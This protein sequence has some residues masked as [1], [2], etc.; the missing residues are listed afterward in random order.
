[1]NNALTGA[2]PC[3]AGC[4][5]YTDSCFR[6]DCLH[7]KEEPT[8]N[9]NGHNIVDYG[10]N[11]PAT[12]LQRAFRYV[13]YNARGQ[14]VAAFNRVED[15]TYLLAFLEYAVTPKKF[16]PITRPGRGGY[17]ITQMEE[18]IH[19]QLYQGVMVNRETEEEEHG[20]TAKFNQGDGR[21][22]EPRF[23]NDEGEPVYMDDYDFLEVVR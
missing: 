9:P 10:P 14:K 17:R 16:Y 1:M 5:Y 13:L 19:N 21:L 12:G 6:T 23:Y 18:P 3:Y 20:T 11:H 22:E 15:S 7:Q 4:F 8:M 2:T